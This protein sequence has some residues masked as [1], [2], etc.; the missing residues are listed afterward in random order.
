MSAWNF[1]AFPWESFNCSSWHCSP[2]DPR[3]LWNPQS[4]FQ[5][6][7][8]C[9]TTQYAEPFLP[10][11][12]HELPGLTDQ[13]TRLQ[14]VHEHFFVF[15]WKYLF[16]IGFHWFFCFSLKNYKDSSIY[17]SPSCYF[18]IP[19]NRLQFFVAPSS[20]KQGFHDWLWKF[21][22]NFNVIFTWFFK[23]ASVYFAFLRIFAEVIIVDGS[24]HP[25]FTRIPV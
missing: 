21:C 5:M 6:T 23:R 10:E 12:D 1:C 7:P 15:H 24:Y 4:N 22:V 16:F 13:R 20:S 25:P 19:P 11:H 17:A 3:T 9:V 8:M 2:F 14:A 18:P